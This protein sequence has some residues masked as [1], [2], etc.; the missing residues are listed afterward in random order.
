MRCSARMAEV[1]FLF[2]RE[3][4]VKVALEPGDDLEA[5]LEKL[6]DIALDADAEDFE[7]ED[8]P[9]GTR[10]VEVRGASAAP[11][12]R[13]WISSRLSS[14]SVPTLRYTNLLPR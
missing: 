3:G 9:D 12:S 11:C 1:K 7:S 10:A 14:S 2:R 8:L 5:N 4:R 13:S 6:V